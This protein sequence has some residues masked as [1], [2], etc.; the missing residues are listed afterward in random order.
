LGTFA[1]IFTSI[2][3]LSPA[4]MSTANASDFGVPSPGVPSPGVP[5]RGSSGRSGRLWSLLA[6]S[7]T[8]SRGGATSALTRLGRVAR[9][10]EAAAREQERHERA[11]S[12]P[13][14]HQM[15]LPLDEVELQVPARQNIMSQQG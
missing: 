12:D 9:E 14:A 11:A 2:F 10:V 4:D 1:S 5:S 15:H 6:G 13:G 8:R 7:L 3:G